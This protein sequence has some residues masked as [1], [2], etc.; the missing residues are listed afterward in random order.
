VKRGVMSK[1][2]V[3]NVLRGEGAALAAAVGA[4]PK[5]TTMRLVLES[6]LS[7]RLPEFFTSS[8]YEALLERRPAKRI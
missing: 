1:G 2:D 7:N 4:E 8:A 6:T 3:A 5:R